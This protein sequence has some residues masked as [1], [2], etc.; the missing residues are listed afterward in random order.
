MAHALPIRTSSGASLPTRAPG[1]GV[2]RAMENCPRG[3]FRMA[4]DSGRQQGRAGRIF[5]DLALAPQRIA[6]TL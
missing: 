5:E 6:P 3:Q 2:S 1:V 4:F